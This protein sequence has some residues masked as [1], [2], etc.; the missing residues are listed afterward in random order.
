LREAKAVEEFEILP[1]A[2]DAGD[3]A[4]A[5][6][7]VL[8]PG[9]NRTRSVNVVPRAFTAADS[10]L[11]TLGIIDRGPNG[12]FPSQQPGSKWRD[13]NSN[14][15]DIIVCKTAAV[16]GSRRPSVGGSVSVRFTESEVSYE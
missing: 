1:R 8:V 16:I 10:A 6:F 15:Y 7:A 2:S 9:T 13:G 11:D 12:A 14:S 3:A 5:A 4:M